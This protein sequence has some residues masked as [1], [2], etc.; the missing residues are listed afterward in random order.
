[1]LSSVAAT[2][3]FLDPETSEQHLQFMLPYLFDEV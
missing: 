2:A 1:L 3:W